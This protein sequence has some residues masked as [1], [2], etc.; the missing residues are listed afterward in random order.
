M[1]VARLELGADMSTE[2][3]VNDGHDPVRH[4]YGD[5]ITGDSSG[6]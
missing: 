5:G 6:I 4:G 2:T 3:V 1:I